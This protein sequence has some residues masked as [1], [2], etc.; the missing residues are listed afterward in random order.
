MQG[1]E[2]AVSAFRSPERKAFLEGSPY[3]G[4]YRDWINPDGVVVRVD[5]GLFR[6]L[7]D[8]CVTFIEA[9]SL[10]EAN[11]EARLPQPGERGGEYYDVLCLT[12]ALW[13]TDRMLFL[14][15]SRRMIMSWLLRCCDTWDAL[16]HP[17]RRLYIS[18]VDLEKS[19]EMVYRSLFLYNHIPGDKI[20][21]GV[22]PPVQIVKSKDSA[23]R[24]DLINRFTVRHDLQE[25][26]AQESFIQGI[27][28]GD[29]MRS[30]GAAR[31]TIEEAASQKKLEAD[32]AG[33][34]GTMQG[35]PGADGRYTGGQIVFITTP[36]AASY[37]AEIVKDKIN[38]RRRAA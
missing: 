37:A 19:E 1:A 26:G 36:D 27:P 20:A 18:S 28:Q 7:S 2:A 38:P 8:C 21:R 34:L 15:K 3:V 5:Y 23:G 14:D 11:T 13:Q 10:E 17:G 4:H 33:L 12:A 30:L 32:L 25:P 6:W 24:G 9:S 31:V 16:F 22:L 29:D 35:K